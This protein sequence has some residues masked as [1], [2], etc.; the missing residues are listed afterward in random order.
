MKTKRGIFG[1]TLIELLIVIGIISI[2]AGIVIIAVNPA[3]QF[4]VAR[5]AERKS[6]IRTIMDAI[7]QYSIDRRGRIVSLL[8][9]GYV[10]GSTGSIVINNSTGPDEINLSTLVADYIPSYIP[11]D[12]DTSDNRITGYV[13]ILHA[14][15]SLTIS[16]PR[17][18]LGVEIILATRTF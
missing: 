5:N 6:E 11:F 3:R 13:F 7:T 17:A 8:P 18:E 15:G 14:N 16:A 10:T 9:V 1:F 4:A 12:P 2:L